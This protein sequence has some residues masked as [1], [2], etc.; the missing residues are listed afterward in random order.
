MKVEKNNIILDDEIVAL[1]NVTL[2]DVVKQ[3]SPFDV[4]Q[5][6]LNVGFVDGSSR[7]M[8]M[9]SSQ[10]RMRVFH[11]LS[12]LGDEIVKKGNYNFGN[13]GIALINMDYV[14]GVTYNVATQL[15][16]IKLSDDQSATFKA[17]PIQAKRILTRAE[18]AYRYYNHINEQQL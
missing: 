5:F 3:G 6:C 8:D 16:T 1:D 14:L 9:T 10:S 11:S 18:D 2:I 7:T 17:S 15:I 12:N 13:I 4:P